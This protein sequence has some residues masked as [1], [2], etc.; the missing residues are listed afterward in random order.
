MN[1]DDLIKK[2]ENIDLPKIGLQSHKRRLK[3]T[4]LNSGYRK[5]KTSMSLLKKFAPIG[6]VAAI[7]LLVI[8]GVNYFKSSSSVSN[9]SL[10]PAAYAKELVGKTE[11]QLIKSNAVAGYVEPTSGLF[12]WKETDADGNIRDEKGRIIF[13]TDQDGKL[14]P[15]PHEL[16]DQDKNWSGEKMSFT[17]TKELLLAS[18]QEAQQAEDLTYL[19]D[20]LVNGKRIKVLQFSD[21]KG[22]QVQKQTILGIDENNMPVVKIIYND[23]G[24]VGGGVIFQRGEI[25]NGNQPTPSGEGVQYGKIDPNAPRP[26]S[27]EEM[28]NFW[29]ENLEN[30]FQEQAEFKAIK[31]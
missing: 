5:E 1:K 12:Q 13:V 16:P 24:G 2:L 28:M 9:L 11:K 30:Q 6:A 26:K 20:K 7:A 14:V 10:T 25:K 4:L 18:L 19:G 27:I 22:A 3:T 31:K 29:T 23:K 17:F 15:V 8:V 21:S